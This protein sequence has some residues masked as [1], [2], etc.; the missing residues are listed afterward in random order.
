ME[1]VL[2]KMK[3]ANVVLTEFEF[4]RYFIGVHLL[5]RFDPL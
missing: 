4:R 2:M 1:E 3:F 5:Q